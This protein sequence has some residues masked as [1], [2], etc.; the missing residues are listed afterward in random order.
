MTYDIETL[1]ALRERVRE[2]TWPDREL[3]AL[4][5]GIEDTRPLAAAGGDRPIYK[6]CPDDAVAFD[7][8]PPFTASIDASL[9]LVE[10]V[11]PGWQHVTWGGVWPYGGM[12]ELRSGGPECFVSNG[13]AGT[14]PLAILDALLSA[15]IEREGGAS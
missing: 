14:L 5:W 10:R 15:L 6:Q 9:A 13:E 4:I 2:A 3:D 1:R 8:P 7:S 12:A 11:L